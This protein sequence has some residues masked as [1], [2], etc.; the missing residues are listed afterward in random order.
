VDFPCT[1]PVGFYLGAELAFRWFG[2]FWSSIIKLNVLYFLLTF[3]WM[4]G[5]LRQAIQNRYLALALVVTC[6]SMTLILAS[7]WLLVV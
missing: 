2:I 7:Y 5:V 3:F 6:E 1:V 4:Y